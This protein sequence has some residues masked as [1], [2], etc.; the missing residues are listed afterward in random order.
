MRFSKWHALGNSYRRRPRRDGLRA[1]RR[2]GAE[3][4]RYGARR[5]RARGARSGRRRSGTRPRSM[6]PDG[7]TSEMSGQHQDRGTVACCAVRRRAVVVAVAP[8]GR[9]AHARGRSRRDR[10]RSVRGRGGGDARRSRQSRRAPSGLG[11]EPACG[12]GMRGPD[13]EVLL[14]LG[15]LIETHGRFPGRT[16]VQFVHAD[17]T[18][19][20]RALVW[21]RGPARRR[22]RGR[23]RL[24][25][26]RRS[27]RPAHARAVT[28][29]MPG[30]SLEVRLENGRAT[31]IGPAE[32]ICHGEVLV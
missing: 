7:S 31:L 29:R 11:G 19:D 25:L 17:G 24:P 12:R 14:R 8:R 30:G 3:A 21:E 26:L 20:A 5:R 4:V 32:E 22:R 16:N 10:C 2:A 27:S 23:P 28:V 6:E 1:G 9:G 15:P 18:H 13:R